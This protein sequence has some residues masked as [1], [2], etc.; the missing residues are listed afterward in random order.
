M[1]T[2]D[3]AVALEPELS[4]SQ[5][6]LWKRCKRRWGY[7]YLEGK[8]EASGKSA[9]A[10]TRVHAVLEKYLRDGSPID[11]TETWNGYPIGAIAL[12]MVPHLPPAGTVKNVEQSLRLVVNNVTFTG[13]VDAVHDNTVY[14]HKTT[15]NLKNAKS[16]KTLKTDIQALIYAR[17]L[18]KDG[19]L[20]WTTGQTKDVIKTKKTFL[21]VI[22]EE[23]HEAFDNIVM[24]VA[25]EILAAYEANEPSKL[26]RNKKA[27][28]FVPPNGCPHRIPCAIEES[29]QMYD[30]KKSLVSMLKGRQAEELGISD[31]IN[32]PITATAIVVSNGN[33]TA[34]IEL[35]KKTRKKKEEAVAPSPEPG[36]KPIRTL[37]I[38][39]I[40]L[41]QS[42]M[43][44]HELMAMAA[45]TVETDLDLPHVKLAPFNT[46]G[47]S[48]A[49][50]LRQ[51]IMVMEIDGG[52]DLVL[53]SRTPEGRD[54]EQ[55]LIS[56][57]QHVVM[58]I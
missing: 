19:A 34:A 26:E 50:Q 21:K 15:S 1:P 22:R 40:P 44:A 31:P 11:A 2:A 32:P 58:S 52:F 8:R 14:D 29:K 42:V 49:A 33:G 10:G 48:L 3:L 28:F 17:W 43:Y 46:G 16:E 41:G 6:D 56:L 45:R 4:A 35:P 39:C 37:Y 47:A 27:C 25:R 38:N 18:D 5:M 9:E 7:S 13:R 51:D 24:P 23:V 36:G 54:C 30:N 57:A 12:D 55:V 20:Q 53:M